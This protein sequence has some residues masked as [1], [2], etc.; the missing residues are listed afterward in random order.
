MYGLVVLRQGSAPLGLRHLERL[1][2]ARELLSARG[3]DTARTALG[4]YSGSGFDRNGARRET[5]SR[6]GPVL[7]SAAFYGLY[8]QIATR[9]SGFDPAV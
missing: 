8:R 6:Q 3:Y 1:A 2:R 5:V 4:M 9:F 7:I